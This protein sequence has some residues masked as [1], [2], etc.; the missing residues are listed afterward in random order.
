MNLKNGREYSYFAISQGT[1]TFDNKQ[2]ATV[3][4]SH[5]RSLK[6]H[7]DVPPCAPSLSI[8]VSCDSLYNK[9]S[10]ALPL[11]PCASD[12]A[13]Y[14]LYYAN[15]VD[16]PLDSLTYISK[17]EQLTF[18]HFP[19]KNLGGA[20]AIVA[21]DSVG[22]RSEQTRA[23][24][25]DSCSLYELPNVFTPNS[26]GKNDLFVPVKHTHQFVDRI[27]IKIFNRYGE[28]VFETTNPEIRW[29]GKIK[30]SNKSASPGVYYYICDIWELRSVGVFQGP[31]KVGFV[32]LLS[33]GA[34][35]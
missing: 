6:P 27:A 15:L 5:V 3:N 13:G 14:I 4:R 32:Y 25:S 7:D 17:V 33:E 22:N 10:W 11:S 16:N 18:K 31:P 24:A 21:V 30:G 20:Y 26:D 12:V 9:L 29:D 1:Y 2:F 23:V 28:L 19:S 35:N 34:N 8:E